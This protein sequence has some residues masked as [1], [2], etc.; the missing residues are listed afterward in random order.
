MYLWNVGGLIDDLRN[1]SVSEFEKLKYL[2]ATGVLVALFSDPI[3]S[4]GLRYTIMEALNLA[5]QLAAVAAGTYYCYLQ[6]R[7]GDDTDFATRFVCLGIPVGLRVLAAALPFAVL[8]GIIEGASG[9]GA[10]IGEQTYT[11]TAAEVAA[12][13]LL[14][15]AYYAYLARQIRVVSTRYDTRPSPGVA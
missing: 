8:L 14:T 13:A 10:D 4:W 1:N 11:T 7:K 2:M 12:Y 9:V 5:L 3:F 15:A 6:N